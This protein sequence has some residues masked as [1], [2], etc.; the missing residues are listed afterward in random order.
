[1]AV[2]KRTLPLDTINVIK[3]RWDTIEG[4]YSSIGPGCSLRTF[5]TMLQ[6]SDVKKQY[7]DNVMD[8]VVDF[9][10][11][12]EFLTE[13]VRKSILKRYGSLHEAY[14]H[15]AWLKDGYAVLQGTAPTDS[16]VKN[17]IIELLLDKR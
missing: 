3:T 4:A 5:Y 8:A 1:M 6:G 12:Q 13:D 2:I 16:R 10:P 15:I 11:V 14:G 9:S 7:V 17:F